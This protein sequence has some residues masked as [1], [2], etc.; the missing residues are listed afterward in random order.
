MVVDV[1]YEGLELAQAAET[2]EQDGGLFV[3]LAAPMPVGTQLLLRGSDGDQLVRVE[4]V[5]E[6]PA[7]SGVLVKPV[8]ATA[9]AGGTSAAALPETDEP[10]DAP[11]EGAPAE[12]APPEGAATDGG[13]KKRGHKKRKGGKTAEPSQPASPPGG[14]AKGSRH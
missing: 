11:P 2:R 7:S 9:A 1:L 10:E 13:H 5:S 8:E 3:P 6:V 14:P 4:R 12:D